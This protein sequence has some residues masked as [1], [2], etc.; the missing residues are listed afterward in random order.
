MKSLSCL[1]QSLV[2]AGCHCCGPSTF[3]LSSDHPCVVLPCAPHTSVPQKGPEQ[4][5]AGCGD[6]NTAATI[7]RAELMIPAV[8]H[9]SQRRPARRYRYLRLLYPL[10]RSTDALRRGSAGDRR[11]E[12]HRH[13]A[14]HH[15]TT[16][17]PGAVRHGTARHGTARHGTA[18]HGDGVA[19]ADSVCAGGRCRCRCRCYCFP[20]PSPVRRADD[21]TETP[22]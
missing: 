11:R 12:K 20:P 10:Y 8:G 13:T 9:R 6:H 3:F 18:R 21:V 7:C 17:T 1:C 14:R 22:V 4:R 16:V 19:R 5:R 2:S 15:T